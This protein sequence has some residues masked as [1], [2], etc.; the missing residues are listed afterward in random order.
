[1]SILKLIYVFNAIPIN[2]PKETW[3]TGFKLLWKSESL[4]R[5]KVLKMNKGV[6]FDSDFKA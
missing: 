2:I 4:R 6:G 3:Y 1:M 5:I